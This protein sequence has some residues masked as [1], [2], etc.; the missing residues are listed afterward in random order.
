MPTSCRSIRGNKDL[1]VSIA[2][3]ATLHAMRFSASFSAALQNSEIFS[4][5]PSVSSL[6]S[7]SGIS[8]SFWD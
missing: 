7:L 8:P 5:Q 4:S 2:L 6:P 1:S 3:N